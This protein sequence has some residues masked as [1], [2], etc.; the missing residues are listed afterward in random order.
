MNPHHMPAP[1]TTPRPITWVDLGFDDLP[2][3]PEN[4]DFLT[5]PESFQ[6]VVAERFERG[7]A[8]EQARIEAS[9]VVRE[10]SNG[11]R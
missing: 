10:S 3:P 11:C 2:D 6:V 1:W 5:L 9:I 7:T 4:P 8:R